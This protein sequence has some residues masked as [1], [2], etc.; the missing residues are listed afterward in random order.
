MNYRLDEQLIYDIIFLTVVFTLVGNMIYHAIY[1][2]GYQECEMLSA[3]DS[4]TYNSFDGCIID[5]VKQ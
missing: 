3:G 2:T 1:Q 4:F 5:G